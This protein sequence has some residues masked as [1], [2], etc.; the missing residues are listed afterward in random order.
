MVKRGVQRLLRFYDLGNQKTCFKNI[1][2]LTKL[3][4]NLYRIL[5]SSFLMLL[6]AFLNQM[7]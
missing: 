3:S 7:R 2:I 4:Y 1:L 5:F 6:S